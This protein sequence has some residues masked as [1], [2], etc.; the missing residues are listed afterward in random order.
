[1]TANGAQPTL[2]SLLA[3]GVLP[4]VIGDLMKIGGAAALT[5]AITPKEAFGGEVDVK[6]A[7]NWRL[8]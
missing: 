3:M 7:G 1:M 5:I 6:E 4:F 8:F 2:W